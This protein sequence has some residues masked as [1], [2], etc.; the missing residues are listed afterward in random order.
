MLRDVCGEQIMC[1]TVQRFLGSEDGAITVDWIVL[2]ASILMVGIATVFFLFEEG[3]STT[4]ADSSTAL[5][6]V[7]A[8]T[9]IDRTLDT[10]AS[11][12]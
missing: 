7:T 6:E 8:G 11:Q 4:I 10:F 1:K 9:G 2:T 5:G 12:R 3:V